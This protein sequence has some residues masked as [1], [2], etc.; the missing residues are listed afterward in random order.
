MKMAQ[1]PNG[2]EIKHSAIP[3]DRRLGWTEVG[4]LFGCA[5]IEL[6]TSRTHGLQDIPYADCPSQREYVFRFD[7][8]EYV[9]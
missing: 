3:A 7:G 1:E 8:R 9:D 6:L 4:S 5:K 2:V